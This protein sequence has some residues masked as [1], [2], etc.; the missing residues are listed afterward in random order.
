LKDG[1]YNDDPPSCREVRLKNTGDD[2]I[3]LVL[4]N[5]KLPRNN[6][7]GPRRQ[8]SSKDEQEQQYGV[9][10]IRRPFIPGR[11]GQKFPRD[12]FNPELRPEIEKQEVFSPRPPMAPDSGAA[13][14]RPP[15]L[16]PDALLHAAEAVE[17]DGAVTGLDSEVAIISKN[18]CAKTNS[19]GNDKFC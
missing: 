8:P 6:D 14:A 19:T 2:V 1:S 9:K 10:R 4:A 12:K 13:N 15:A 17:H 7:Q 5:P 11:P 18:Q 16:G 3:P